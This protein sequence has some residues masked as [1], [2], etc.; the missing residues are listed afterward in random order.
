MIRK[1]QQTN[2]EFIERLLA[3]HGDSP[4]G[5]G[6]TDADARIRYPVML[7]VLPSRPADAS[8]LDF[9]C[10]TGHLLEYLRETGPAGVLYHGSDASPAL[11]E[12]CRGKF[13]GVDFQVLDALDPACPPWPQYD[14]IVMNGLLT[15]KLGASHAEFFDYAKA[16]LREVFKHCRAGLA[17][18]VM[19][20]Q[21]DWERDE[22]FHLGLDPLVDFLSR[23][24]S[25]HFRIRADYGLYEYTVYVYQQPVSGGAENARRLVGAGRGDRS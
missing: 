8:L 9:G 23:E 3:T 17:F 5:V 2:V 1:T 18:N 21:V 25:R 10:G 15:Y 12:V 24:L 20:K 11:V 4:R 16:L 19:S 7:D 6:W 13:P 14:Y 22:L